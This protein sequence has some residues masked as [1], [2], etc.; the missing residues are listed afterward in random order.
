MLQDSKCDCEK[1]QHGTL[2]KHILRRWVRDGEQNIPASARQIV[3]TCDAHI[4][5]F[6]IYQDVLSESCHDVFDPVFEFEA[7][8]AYKQREEE[9]DD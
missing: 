3:V 7:C 9:S 1:C 4:R 6:V 8:E 5:Q 2:H